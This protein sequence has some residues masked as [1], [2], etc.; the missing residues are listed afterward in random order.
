M[1]DGVDAGECEFRAEES[2]GQAP[3][4]SSLDGGTDASGPLLTLQ[5]STEELVSQHR[6]ELLHKCLAIYNLRRDR[7][8]IFGLDGLFCEPAW[9]ILLDLFIA[10]LQEKQV[11][12][13]SAAVASCAPLTTALRWLSTLEQNDLVMRAP[14]PFDGRRVHIKLTSVGL[15]TMLRLMEGL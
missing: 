9:D 5:H 2:T 7:D 13:T 14:D 15:A 11:S 10:H 8:R 6:G 1:R 3:G 4:S 12:V